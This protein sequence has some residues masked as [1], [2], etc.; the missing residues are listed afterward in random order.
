MLTL[1]LA[2]GCMEALENRFVFFPDKRITETP[3]D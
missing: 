2:G 3:R 1:F